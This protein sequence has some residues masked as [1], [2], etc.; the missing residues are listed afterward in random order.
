MKN[1]KHCEYYGLILIYMHLFF[2]ENILEACMCVC[3]VSFPLTSCIHRYFTIG[4]SIIEI[5]IEKGFA[6]S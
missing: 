5:H 2:I 6:R 1:V 3:A 4:I